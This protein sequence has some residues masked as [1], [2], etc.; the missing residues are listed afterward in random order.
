MLTPRTYRH[1]ERRRWHIDVSFGLG[2][3]CR[4]LFVQ[5]PGKPQVMFTLQRIAFRAI[6]KRNPVW[7]EQQHYRTGGSR[8]LTSN[9]VPQHGGFSALNP[10]PQAWI[11]T[12]ISV[13]PSPRCCLFTSP[14]V[15]IPVHT[16][17]KCG[18]E[19]LQYVI[20]AAHLRSVLV[21][22]LKPYLVWVSCR[23]KSPPV[24]CEQPQKRPI[25]GSRGG[26]A[27][28][29]LVIGQWGCTA[30]WGRV[31]TAWLTIMGLQFQ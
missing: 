21:R 11:F 5:P 7:C 19:P 31:F 25:P 10:S 14:T 26:R 4:V 15:R 24:Q 2:L 8:L 16:T 28:L 23:R 1:F 22:K 13:G 6:K 18:T 27:F 20:G 12:P 3:C 29:V 30:G 9:I 17:L